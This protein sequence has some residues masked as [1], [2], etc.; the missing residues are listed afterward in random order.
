MLK[1]L[2][3]LGIILIIIL[4]IAVIIVVVLLI[5]HN[6]QLKEEA[7]NYHPAGDVVEVNGKNLHV[8]TEGDGELTLVFMAGHGTSYPTLDFKPIWMRMVDEYRIAVVEKSG[9]GW[10]ETSNSPR[11]IDT[12][13][14]ETRMALEL[15]GEKAPYILFP[16]SMSGL[17]AIYWAQK[18]PEEVKAIIGLDPLTPETV[19]LLPEIQKIQLNLMYFISRIGLPRFIPESELG[20]NLPLMNSN[21]LSE[22]DKK[23]L[24]AIFY[25]SSVTK[26][27]LN[28]VDYLKDNAETIG[29]N[30]VPINT[31]M[32]FFIS[33]AQ[34]AI[35]RGWTES[36]TD[37]LSKITTRKYMLLSSGHYV[38]Y[39]KA[40]IIAEE[41]KAFLKDIK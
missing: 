24:L 18:Y 38:H 22:E 15:S 37:Y 1:I 6:Y 26:D 25:K 40:E 17:E 11:D 31:P 35:A 8:Y 5:N 30:E 33:D 41:A 29:K 14:E 20:V 27:M 28:E 16:H 2:K 23:Q 21:D 39:D 12:M 4:V 34:E 7:K 19:E 10:S 9:Y 36:L 13:L 32:Y 3:I